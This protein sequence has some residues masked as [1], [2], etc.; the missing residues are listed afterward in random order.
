VEA[1]K[2]LKTLRLVYEI[3]SCFLTGT[4]PEN[5]GW[6]RGQDSNL[7]VLAGGGFQDLKVT[8]NVIPPDGFINKG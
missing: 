8:L 7:Q 4:G 1:L 6:L 5:G 2:M 3:V